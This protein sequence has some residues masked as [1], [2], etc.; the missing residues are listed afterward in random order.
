MPREVEGQQDGR[1]HRRV[2]E[3]ATL[4]GAVDERSPRRRPATQKTATGSGCET[5]TMVGRAMN[6]TVNS[7]VVVN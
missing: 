5:R 1:R 6:T 7:W 2:A 3:L 4:A